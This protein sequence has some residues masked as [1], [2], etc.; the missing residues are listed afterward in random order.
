[1]EV[2]N[3]G[4]ATLFNEPKTTA[5]QLETASDGDFPCVS[6]VDDDYLL[7]K[8]KKIPLQLMEKWRKAALVISYA[9]VFCTFVLGISA[10]IVS[11]L[12]GS[13]ATFGFAFDA[14]LDVS[15]TLVVIWRFCGATGHLYSWEKERRAVIIIAILF[16]LSA[17]GIFVKA[18]R[19][20]VVEKEPLKLKS[21]EIISSV[22]VV[23]LGLLAWLKFTI[24]EKLHSVAL[25]TDALN[26]TAGTLMALGMVISTLVYEQTKS[27]WFLDSSVALV[28]AVGL[29]FYGVKLLGT[30]LSSKGKLPPVEHF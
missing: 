10:F 3:Y 1:M 30:L 9:S 20:L 14:I 28:I 22:S 17:A 12:A 25:R 16:V 5:K 24:A 27:T 7:H 6:P 18:I 26:S 29:F 15:S 23:T 13:S 21:L 11:H 2:S 8:E 4:A 19:M